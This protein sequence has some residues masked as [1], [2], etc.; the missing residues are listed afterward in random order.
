[1]KNKI[2]IIVFT[3]VFFILTIP[4]FGN[5]NDTYFLLSTGSPL[6]Y[7]LDVS[8]DYAN[9]QDY[10]DV[11]W[12]PF[13]HTESK[14]IESIQLLKFSYNIFNIFKYFNMTIINI[15]NSNNIKNKELTN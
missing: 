14:K 6:F 7:N 15:C 8:V 1:M 11:S 4:V 3:V 13:Q 5:E 2:S 10:Y 12:S 9:S